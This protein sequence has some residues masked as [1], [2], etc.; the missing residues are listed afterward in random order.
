ML[1]I[2]TTDSPRAPR[3]KPRTL[4]TLAGIAVLAPA[5]A[6]FLAKVSPP[7]GLAAG[8]LAA[9]VGAWAAL[10]PFSRPLPVTRPRAVLLLWF[11]LWSLSASGAVQAGDLERLKAEAPEKYLDRIK[12]SRSDAEWLSALKELRPDQYAQEVAR[13]EAEKQRDQAEAAERQ[14]AAD[15]ARQQDYPRRIEAA[16]SEI[17][18]TDPR[19]LNKERAFSLFAS[20]ASLLEEGRSMQMSAPAHAAYVKLKAEA[21][22]FQEKAFPILRAGYAAKLRDVAWENDMSVRAF[23]PGNTIVEYVW[24][25]FAAN[26]NI[27]SFSDKLD[28]VHLQLRFKRVQFKWFEGADKL[29]YY[30]PKPAADRDIII[31]TGKSFRRVD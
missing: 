14:A 19:H 28:D 10:R 5:L 26:R 4:A 31:W 23:G 18:R 20:W 3:I 1:A 2:E 24:A 9:A 7:V 29:T 27:K 13:R 17:R 22:A 8:A 12:R 16:L 21:S 11:A 25:G 15:R 30:E 6:V